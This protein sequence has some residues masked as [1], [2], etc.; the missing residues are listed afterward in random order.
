MSMNDLSIL[1]WYVDGLHNLFWVYKGHAGAMFTRG[2]GAVS[3]YSRKLKLNTQSSTE[4][5][6]VGADMYMPKMLWCLY[7]TDSQGYDTEITELYQ[8]NKSAELLMK[9]GRFLSRKRTKHI[10]ANFFFIKDRIDDG[11]IKVTPCPIEEMWADVLTKPLQ[12]MAF[13]K[14]HSKL[15]NCPVNYDEE[16]EIEKEMTKQN[17]QGTKT[18]TKTTNK[19]VTSMSPQKCVRHKQLKTVTKN[20]PVGVG[21]ANKTWQEQTSQPKKRKTVEIRAENSL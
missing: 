2:E 21:R 15:M 18:G 9:N 1:K 20:R 13:R 19:Q 5:E 4:M 8:D 14:M 17:Q 7:F 6:L 16:E 10:K 3:S 12:G 11:E